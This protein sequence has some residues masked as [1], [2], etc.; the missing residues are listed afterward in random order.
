MYVINDSNFKNYLSGLLWI[1]NFIII[2]VKENI[3][4]IFVSF[5]LS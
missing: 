4:V 5:F 1:P 3:I 2:F